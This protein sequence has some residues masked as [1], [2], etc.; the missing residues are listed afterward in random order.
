MFWKS[1]KYSMLLLVY[2]II[3][4]KCIF[5][6]VFIYIGEQQSALHRL[7]SLRRTNLD[8]LAQTNI[9]DYDRKCI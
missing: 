5:K 1:N 2:L 6:Y 9:F 4:L 8:M 7:I 3:K